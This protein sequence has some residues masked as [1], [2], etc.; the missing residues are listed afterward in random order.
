MPASPLP[1]NE[2]ARLKALRAL[3][4]LDTPPEAEFEALVQAAAII[5]NTPISLI[6]LVD[7]DRQWFKANTGLPGATETPRDYAFCA[8][9]IHDDGI[10]E[11]EDASCD[12]RFIDN[13][14]VTSDPNIRFYAGASLCLSGG[15]RVGT[16]CVINQQPQKLTE[17]QRNLLVLLAK[18]AVSALES[19]L[20]LA[21]EKKARADLTTMS[22][23]LINAEKRF[24]I[25]SDSSPIGIFST[26]AAGKCT[27]TNSCWQEIYGLSLKESKGDGWQAGLHPEDVQKVFTSW[28]ENSPSGNEFDMEFR[29]QHKD[30][31]VRHVHSRAKPIKSSSGD[32]IEFIGVVEDVTLQKKLLHENRE[33]L[34]VI[35]AQ[36]IVSVTDVQGNIIEVN[37]A[38][39]RIS[40]YSREDL[41]GS[42]H[43][44][45][46][47]KY[48][49]PDFFSDMWKTISG[50]KSWRREICNQAKDGS[51]YWVDS[52]I[53]PLFNTQGQIDRYLSIR[54]D[55][56]EKLIR[57]KLLKMRINI[58]SSPQIVAELASGNLI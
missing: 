10:L 18:A 9:A 41:I 37:D 47:S 17:Q 56:T 26:D 53:S 28:Q 40:Q 27:Y 58:S 3:H 46:N 35:R 29:T 54:S 19:R 13:P 21:N 42:N 55:I 5:C 57:E 14:L 12:P 52:V 24:R 34:D 51:Y 4:V 20:A 16:L 30:G 32:I 23:Q 22:I 33:L 38:F 48:H 39:C 45:I 2:L 43:R 15:E 1:E 36:F 25:L 49:S 44:I 6:S 31:S 11:I 50:G 7:K 8:Y